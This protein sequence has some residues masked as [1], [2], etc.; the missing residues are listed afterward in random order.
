MLCR[1]TVVQR[2]QLKFDGFLAANNWRKTPLLTTSKPRTLQALQVYT[3]L[4]KNRT[5]NSVQS[6]FIH[7]QN[8]YI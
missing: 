2:L 4:Y 7:M 3:V 6:G 1:L 5:Q 8:C